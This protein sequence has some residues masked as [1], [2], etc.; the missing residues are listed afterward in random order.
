MTKI[1]A[2]PGPDTNPHWSPDGKQI[3]FRSAMGKPDFFHSNARIAVVPR[4][5]AATRAPLTDEFDESPILIDWKP[6]GIYFSGL[7]KTASHLFRVD[8]GTTKIT[9]ITGPD[10]LMAGEFSLTHDGRKM[11]FTS[12][13]P[14]SLGEVFLTEVSSFAPRKLTD[15]TEQTKPFILGKPEV[16][17]W[18]SQDGTDDRRRAHQAC[19]LRSVEE[20]PTPVHHPRR[21]DR[22]RSPDVA[23]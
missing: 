17:S 2:Q 5:L 22:H 19:R 15:M 20:T 10:R 11:A 7:Q 8:P 23:V 13:S 18:T 4:R 6:D 14:T 9:R 3:A 16:I 21:S 1:V 12:A